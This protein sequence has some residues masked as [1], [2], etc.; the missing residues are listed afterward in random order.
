MK[1]KLI[2]LSQLLAILFI[3]SSLI[4]P[5]KAQAVT[6]LLQRYDKIASSI[7]SDVTTH[8]IGFVTT[9]TTTPVGSVVIEFC[10]NT[11]IVE[12]PCSFPVGF[13]ASATTL[14]NQSGETGF[15]IHPNSTANRIILTRIPVNPTGVPSVYDFTNITNPSTNGTYFLR[16]KTY[17]STDGSG[18]NIQNGGV[19]IYIN[20]TLNVSGEVPPYLSFCAA[21][22]ITS[23]DCSTANNFF[24][25]F[26]T[27]KTSVTSHA[28]SQFIA[29]SNAI[30]GYSVTISG[31][32]LTSGL[33]TIP[34]M[35]T[36]TAS[37]PG[38]SQFGF[39]LRQNTIPADGSDAVG[40]GTAQP[41]GSYNLPNQYTY[42][43]GDII[44]SVTHSDDTRKFTVSY[45]TNISNSQPG[46]VY[47]TTI[48]FICLANF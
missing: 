32:T 21:V 20:N 37:T 19:V 48:S 13:S 26:G 24:I 10:R 27:F 25:D 47:S 43:N 35:A 4:N 5:V 41:T 44:A 40:P 42:N 34:G 45:V 1:Q 7:A 3:F 30:S 12:D 14:A 39:N 29:A 46:G 8:Q 11:P 36:P 23:F 16:I 17:S 6:L 22:T 31:T 2:N 38:L 18:T 28:T 33:N 9:D 15:S